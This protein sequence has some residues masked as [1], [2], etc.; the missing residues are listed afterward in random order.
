ML[1]VRGL[2]EKATICT[3]HK[4][5]VSR[6]ANFGYFRRGDLVETSTGEKGIVWRIYRS[7]K[8][9]ELTAC[10]IIWYKSYKREKISMFLPVQDMGK[11]FNPIIRK[12]IS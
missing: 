11:R 6:R 10:S 5:N 9:N 8:T 4:E 12:I 7:I 2:F 3:S 1:V